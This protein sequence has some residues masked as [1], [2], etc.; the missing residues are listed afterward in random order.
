MVARESVVRR[1]NLTTKTKNTAL[2][3]RCGLQA[4]RVARNAI[5]F[6][7]RDVRDLLDEISTPFANVPKP[8]CSGMPPRPPAS[9]AVDRRAMLV[10]P[11]F[12]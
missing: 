4:W 3:G 7:L 11:A 10:D 12:S 2:P 9:L 8:Q 1:Q 6:V 5:D